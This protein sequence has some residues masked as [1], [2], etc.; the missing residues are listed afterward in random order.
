MRKKSTMRKVCHFILEEYEGRFKVFSSESIHKAAKDRFGPNQQTHIRNALYTLKLS[1]FIQKIGTQKPSLYQFTTKALGSINYSLISRTSKKKGKV[2]LTSITNKPTRE[3]TI[4]RPTRE[5]VNKA[6]E[7]ILGPAY[8]IKKIE[9]SL[10]Q[11]EEHQHL[12]EEHRRIVEDALS[13][14]KDELEML[15]KIINPQQKK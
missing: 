4:D 10:S 14:L 1:G 2:M 7:T 9:D 5:F 12:I 3:T 6:S 15:Q 11:I 8:Y 13:G